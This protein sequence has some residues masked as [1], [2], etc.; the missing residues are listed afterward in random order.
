M[1]SV[2]LSLILILAFIVETIFFYKSNKIYQSS[3]KQKELKE[4]K[5]DTGALTTRSLTLA[6]IS[7]AIFLVI[8]PKQDYQGTQILI[9]FA[10]CL[11]VVNFFIGE[12]ALTRAIFN[13]IQRR[14]TYYWGYA[15][16]LAIFSAYTNPTSF[17]FSPVSYIVGVTLL[18]LIFLHI[19]AIK[20]EL[21]ITAG[22]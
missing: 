11:M 10:L 3:P 16:L 13:F 9:A 17:R 19:K 12:F 4:Y 7:A 20:Y 8:F 15:I 14:A 6:G 21:N 1:F 2:Y 5:K 18:L 22:R